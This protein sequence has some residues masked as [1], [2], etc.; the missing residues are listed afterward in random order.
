LAE[1]MFPDSD[2][3][4][5]I[6]RSDPRS[7]DLQ[8]NSR[9]SVVRTPE[10]RP[11]AT[12][13]RAILVQ[14]TDQLGD[15]V[16]SIP[17]MVRL[18]AL[19]PDARIVGLLTPANRDLAATLGL[20]D[21]VITIDFPD[22]EVERRRLMPLADQ[23]A[24]RLRLQ[25]YAFDLAID[26]SQAGVSRPLLRLSGAPFLYGVG[27]GAWPWL[28]AGI[29]FNTHDPVTRLDVVPHSAKVLAMIE[30]LGALVG[31]RM[32]VIRRADL[33]RDRLAAFGIAVTDRY[34]V[35]HAGARIAFSRWPHH[36]PLVRLILEGTDRK[37]VL[38]ADDPAIRATLPA[39]LLENDRFRLLNERLPFDDFDALISFADALVGNDSGP[40][41][42]ASLRGVDAVTLF[43]SRINWAEW[44]QETG[45]AIITRKVPCAG[46]AIFH[47]AEECGRDFVCIRGIRPQEVFDTLCDLLRAREVAPVDPYV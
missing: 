22:D 19:F 25:P 3:L 35:L 15:M 20:F 36:A 13:P 43:T 18:R 23:D 30:A 9:A 12:P 31:N 2:G 46:C 1:S 10:R 24:L 21:E 39:D 17:A 29:D 16:A 6:D 28:S 7:T 47:D 44:G 42:L 32:P 27:D 11:L 41:H 45:G 33:S 4:V 38:L 37:V 34:V 26:L 5:E 14:R 40:K 8:V